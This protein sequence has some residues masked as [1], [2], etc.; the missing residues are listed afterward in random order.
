MAGLGTGTPEVRPDPAPVR[1]SAPAQAAAQA[2]AAAK[3]PVFDPAF[4]CIYG[5]SGVGKTLSTCHAFPNALAIAAPNALVSARTML[6]YAPASVYRPVLDDVTKLIKAE[7]GHYDA[8][9]IDDF[10]FLAEQTFAV[11]EKRHTG[12]RLFGALRDSILDFRDAARFAGCHVAV[13]CWE[14]PPNTKPSGERVRGGPM[15]TGRLPEQLP[16]MCDLV[17]RC[18]FDP[19]RKPWPGV[20]RCGG[21]PNYVMKDRFN[22]VSDP[23]PMNLGEILRSAGFVLSRAPGLEWQEDIVE[24]IAVGLLAGEP[25]ND[26]AAANDAY[27]KL[28]AAGARSEHARFTVSDGLD[29]AI[30]RRARA[31]R[32]SVFC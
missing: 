15:L 1:R 31:I 13:T 22:V 29:R 26:L 11:L 25:M 27:T 9:I 5:P 12:F 18:A 21:D 20:Y 3:R 17:L 10:S 7:S 19:A 2:A 24:Q 16:A 30:L 32:E 28:V 14:Q 8:I 4:V 6:G 23:A